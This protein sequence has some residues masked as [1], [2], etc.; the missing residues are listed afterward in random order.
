M[1]HHF[2]CKTDDN[3]DTNQLSVMYRLV[4]YGKIKYGQM[5]SNM[6]IDG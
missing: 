1:F 6:T 4:K 2:Y 3:C 5:R